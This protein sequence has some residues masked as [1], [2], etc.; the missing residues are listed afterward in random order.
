MLP[1]LN[2]VMRSSFTFATVVIW[3][4][5][6][7]TGFEVVH[8]LLYIPAI[9]VTLA[10]VSGL[11]VGGIIFGRVCKKTASTDFQKNVSV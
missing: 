10:A 8:W 9:A 1:K 7:L 5:I 4:G 11:C 6:W 2:C 3:L